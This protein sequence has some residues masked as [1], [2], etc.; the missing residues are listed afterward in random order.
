MLNCIEGQTF[1][2]VHLI[3]T[4]NWLPCIEYCICKGTFKHLVNDYII[5][6]S[7]DSLQLLA[8]LGSM[9]TAFSIPTMMSC[10]CPC[11]DS[12]ISYTTGVLTE[13]VVELYKASLDYSSTFAN[14]SIVYEVAYSYTVVTVYLTISNTVPS[15]IISASNGASYLNGK[16]YITTVKNTWT[17]GSTHTYMYMTYQYENDIEFLSCTCDASC[18]V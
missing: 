17:G 10:I 14:L 18:R 16:A 5:F 6:V 8:A 13:L 3:H 4:K 2:L 15:K 1:G 11:Q 9:T 7:Y 12:F